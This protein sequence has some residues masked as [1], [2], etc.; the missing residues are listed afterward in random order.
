MT[1]YFQND[2]LKLYN[3]NFLE[4]L[5]S[6]KDIKCIISEF[7]NSSKNDNSELS[8]FWDLC[9]K[10]IPV[11][12]FA[13]QPFSNQIINSNP[14][15]FNYQWIWKKNFPFGIS[16]VKKKPLSYYEDILVFNWNE[17]CAYNPIFRKED[18]YPSNI[19]EYDF[20][21]N[22]T[23]KY[24][25]SQKPV[26]LLEYLIQT[27]T[28]ENDVVLDFCGGAGSLAVA[29]FN[30]DRKAIIIEKDKSQCDAILKRISTISKQLTFSFLDEI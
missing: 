30:I 22:R 3:C 20:V 14:E 15:G 19:L 11:I 7:P 21:S 28:K 1:P 13:N 5:A 2:Y 4:V 12:I 23:E 10:G 9:P 25:R 26:E 27:Y 6:L 16:T 18:L 8:S 29:C 17:D 24:H